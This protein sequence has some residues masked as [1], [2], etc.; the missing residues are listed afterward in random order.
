M[1]N[2]LWFN[3][4]MR[5]KE[6]SYFHGTEDRCGYKPVELMIGVEWCQTH[7]ET[8]NRNMT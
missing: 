3:F 1:D 2:I 5:E 8:I 4:H 7:K 6:S